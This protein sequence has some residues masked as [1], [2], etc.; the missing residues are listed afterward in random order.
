M[1]EDSREK[2]GEEKRTICM[3]CTCLCMQPEEAS[4]AVALHYCL[5]YSSSSEIIS[6]WSEGGGI[7]NQV[8]CCVGYLHHHACR[9]EGD[10]IYYGMPS[11]A[12]RALYAV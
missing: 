2:E 6:R 1:E 5:S 3:Q 12:T 11:P 8:D 9:V 4:Q 10:I 7:L